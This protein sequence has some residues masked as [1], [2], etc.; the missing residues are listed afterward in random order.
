MLLSEFYK[1]INGAHHTQDDDENQKGIACY[2]AG[3]DFG[4]ITGGIDRGGKGG[5]CAA[6]HQNQA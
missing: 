2:G 5:A 4:G 6:A 1:Q 3:V